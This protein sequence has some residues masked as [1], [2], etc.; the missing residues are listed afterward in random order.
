MRALAENP[1]DSAAAA[2]I[3]PPGR[4]ASSPLHACCWG[5]GPSV[6]RASACPWAGPWE[7]AWT[8]C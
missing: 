5:R 6:G 8:A 3:Q 1:I 4:C 7:L 2:T